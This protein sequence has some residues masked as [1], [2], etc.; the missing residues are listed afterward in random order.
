MRSQ[1]SLGGHPGLTLA[2]SPF[3]K[4]GQLSESSLSG[5]RQGEGSRSGEMLDLWRK[6]WELRDP[7]QKDM[8]GPVGFGVLSLAEKGDFAL[9]L[10]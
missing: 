6:A 5:H 8:V 10:R 3:F 7:G 9:S 2:S 4:V 1:P